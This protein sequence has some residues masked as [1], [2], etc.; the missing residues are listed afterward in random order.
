MRGFFEHPCGSRR[1]WCC[2]PKM[3]TDPVHITKHGSVIPKSHLPLGHATWLHIKGQ[4]LQ[5]T[6][7]PLAMR[8]I[9]A[10]ELMR[11]E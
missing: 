4:R 8:S 5:G 9:A 1:A 11:D 10:A 6:H 7:R 2:Q 3:G